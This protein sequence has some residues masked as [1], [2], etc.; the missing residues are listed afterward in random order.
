MKGSAERWLVVVL[1]AGLV[2]VGSGCATRQKANVEPEAVPAEPTDLEYNRV[3]LPPEVEET[4]DVEE[5]APKRAEGISYTVR[6]GD[7]LWKIAR[8]HAVS[9]AEIKDYNTLSN[10][11][12]LRVGQVIMLPPN[13]H[14]VPVSELPR[15]KAAPKS[16]PAVTPYTGETIDYVIKQGDT[17]SGIAKAH[18]TTSALIRGANGLTGDKIVAGRKLKIPAAKQ[19]EP[20]VAVPVEQ[21]TLTP[22]P[23]PMTGPATLEPAPSTTTIPAESPAAGT[24]APPPAGQTPPAPIIPD[25]P[26]EPIIQ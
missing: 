18:G 22:E 17:L 3:E 26:A 25:V 16:P 9:V 10:P 15:K 14:E 12:K 2:M 24:I 23:A 13:A 8:C 20:A 7:N 19:Q 1:A 11:E 21:P 6:A 5:E 4:P